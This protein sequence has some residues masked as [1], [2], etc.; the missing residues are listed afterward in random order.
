[1]L[2]IGAACAPGVASPLM[3][4]AFVISLATVY[5]HL[6]LFF[7][8]GLWRP[9]FLWVAH[10][11]LTSKVGL[12]NL[13]HLSGFEACYPG[14]SPPANDHQGKARGGAIGQV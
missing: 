8:L 1:M 10:A 12:G 11:V 6:A 13:L 2:S 7:H 3:Q 9:G 4:H 5:W 14:S